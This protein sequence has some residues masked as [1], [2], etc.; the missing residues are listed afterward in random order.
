MLS[1]KFERQLFMSKERMIGL[2]LEL[3]SLRRK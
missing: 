3:M 1:P 2:A